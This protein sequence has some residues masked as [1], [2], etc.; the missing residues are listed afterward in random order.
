MNSLALLACGLIIVVGSILWLR[1][2]AFLALVLGAYTVAL[3]T[4][5]TALRGYADARVTK[6]ELTAK[7]AA[8]FPEKPAASRVADE[9]GKTCANLGIL[10]AMAT[11][12][13]EAMLLSG[14]AES[15]A[16]AM[17]RWLGAAR[18]HW[19]FF[20]TSFLLC[21]PVM[22]DTVMVL[23]APLLKAVA[24][25]T[26]R[27]Y[28]LLVLCTVAGGTITHSLVPPTPGPLFVAGELGVPLG[29]MIGMGSGIGLGAALTGVAFAKVL[30]RNQTLAIPDEEHTAPPARDLPPLWIALIP[31]ILPVALIGLDAS[32]PRHWFLSTVGD[33]DMALTLGAIA[34][35][36]PLVF[37]ADKNVASKAVGTALAS[38]AVIVLIIGA[39]GAFGGVLRQTG[40]AEVFGTLLGH[41]HAFVLPVVFLITMLVRTA[42][43]SATVAMITAAPIA[44]AFIES[45]SAQVH[46]V[47]FAIAIGCGSKPVA[48]MNDAGFWIISKSSGL[49]ERQTLR[50]VTPMMALQGVAG[51]VLTMLCAWIW[52]MV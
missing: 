26:Q 39:G 37:R 51:L 31:V 5:A 34:A 32:F 49:S 43:G 14:A 45:G 35:L 27:D 7:A 23:L 33:K 2:H 13:G 6:G 36:L 17:L 9:F 16:A 40:I 24:R 44:K 29:L 1:L 46:P 22:L 48:W 4:P 41:A 19:A 28:L 42:Q 38:G 21:I 30:N 15:I 12:I 3:L 20:T 25:K 11:I 10:I 47:Y 18:A 8:Q 50:T 52:P